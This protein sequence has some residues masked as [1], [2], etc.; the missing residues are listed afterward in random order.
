MECGAEALAVA[1]SSVDGIVGY[2]G[3]IAGEDIDGGVGG[4]DGAGVHFES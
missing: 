2:E 3:S 1:G 4:E